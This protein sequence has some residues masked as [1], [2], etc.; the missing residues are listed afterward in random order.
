MKVLQRL[1]CRMFGHDWQESAWQDEG[2]Q[3]EE[4]SRCGEVG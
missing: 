2:E 4:C 1:W 3:L